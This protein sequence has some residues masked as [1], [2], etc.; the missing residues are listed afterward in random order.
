MTY[1]NDPC[2]PAEI[3]DNTNVPLTPEFMVIATVAPI[4]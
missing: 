1:K 3:G 2:S 4:T